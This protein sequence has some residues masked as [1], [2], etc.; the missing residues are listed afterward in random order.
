MSTARPP[1][2][3]P[4]KRLLVASIGVAT[5]TYVSSQ[6]GCAAEHDD[7]P[8]VSGNLISPPSVEPALRNDGGLL[9]ASGNLLPPP[10][11]TIVT[12]GNLLPP[13][14]ATI[15]TSGNLLPPPDASYLQDAE[16]EDAATDASKPKDSGFD[17]DAFPPSG[18]LLPPPVQ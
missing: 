1:A 8:A 13:P 11:A 18:N 4:G 9:D 14:D 17:K 12:S 15:V 16:P 3:K 2:K 5:I 6:T 10:D 7:D